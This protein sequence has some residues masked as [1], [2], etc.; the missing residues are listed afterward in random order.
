MAVYQYHEAGKESVEV[1]LASTVKTASAIIATGRAVFYG[2][3]M[4]TDS[5]NDITLSL[6]DGTTAAGTP[7]LPTG[8]TVDGTSNMTSISFSPPLGCNTGIYVD[9]SVAASGTG[10]YTVYYDA[11]V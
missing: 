8:L 7:L 2:I 9:M 10:S 5:V 11:V 3:A 6:Y 1:Q 4:K